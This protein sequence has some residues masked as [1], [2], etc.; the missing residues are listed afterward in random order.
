[1]VF[2]VVVVP[3]ILFVF[4][5]VWLFSNEGIG[6][7]RSDQ[8]FL[9]QSV[10]FCSCQMVRSVPWG[11]SC[12]FQTWASDGF[13]GGLFHVAAFLTHFWCTMSHI[14][15]GISFDPSISKPCSGLRSRI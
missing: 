3:F 10:V 8:R 11:L 7:L 12:S 1:M 2:L 13:S 5:V 15:I 14:V 6:S 4:L 9:G